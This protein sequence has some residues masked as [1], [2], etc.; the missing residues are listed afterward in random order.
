MVLQMDVKV[1]GLQKTEARFKRLGLDL[2]DFSRELRSSGKF[3]RNF[4]STKV[5][6][7]GGGAINEVW[8]PLKEGG[9]SVL[10]DTGALQGAFRFRNNARLLS[11]SNRTPYLKW[12][13]TGTKHMPQR[14]VMKV[15]DSLAKS[16]GLIF[17]KGINRRIRKTFTK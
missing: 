7:A 5:V 3:M 17:Q 11:F 13:Q 4:Y 1:E 9:R 16:I 15:T 10:V 2:R 8:P 6:G 12:H 14:M